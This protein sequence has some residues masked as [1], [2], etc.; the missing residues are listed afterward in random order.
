MSKERLE[1]IKRFFDEFVFPVGRQQPTRK[2]M[3]A[4][5]AHESVN[6]LIQQA[7]EKMQLEERVKELENQLQVTGNEL[8]SL[9]DENRQLK[10]ALEKIV[11]AKGEHF[12]NEYVEEVDQI[13]Y[14]ALINTR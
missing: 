14:N 12:L 9:S 1:V 8:S 6:W 11:N 2:H 10:L 7:E 3:S 13:A 5:F 4:L